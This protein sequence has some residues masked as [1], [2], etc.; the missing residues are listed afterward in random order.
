M[1]SACAAHL[2]RRRLRVL[3][4]DG[5]LPPHSLGSSHGRTRIIR[6]GYFEGELYVPLVRRAYELWRQLE[7][8]EGSD[9][10]TVT[11]ALL[12]GPEGSPILGST[13]ASLRHHHVL[14]EVLDRE[15]LTVRYPQ[16]AA[17]PDGWAIH[18]PGA[19]VLRLEAC[20]EAHLRAARRLGADLR[21]HEPVRRWTARQDGVAVDT[22]RARYEADSLVLAVGPWLPDEVATLPLTIERQVQVWFSPRNESIRGTDFPVFLLHTPSNA[23]MYGIPSDDLGVKVA[24]HHGGELGSVDNLTREVSP[25]EVSA[26]RDELARHIP[27]ASGEVVR[28]TV[29][30]YTNTPDKHFIIDRHPDHH[31]VLLVSACSGHGFKFSPVIGE[32]VAAWIADDRPPEGIEGF[33]LARLRHPS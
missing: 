30:F 15:A 14:H 16:I 3:G 10:L 26:V 1:G 9:L 5:F 25:A 20:L 13:L 23:L 21:F 28:A 32:R 19:G 31:R 22:D 6:E 7:R 12:I 29:C 33:G 8:E 27:A 17:G 2:A 24:F 18:E 4:I 11:G